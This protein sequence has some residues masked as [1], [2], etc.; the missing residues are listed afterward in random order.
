MPLLRPKPLRAAGRTLM[1]WVSLLPLAASGAGRQDVVGTLPEDYFPELKTIL[2][3][4][5]ERAPRV[6]A[7]EIEIALS[8]ARRDVADAPRL[9]Q[10]AAYL[11]AAGNQTS[12]SG[13]EGTRSRDQGFFYNVALNQAL[14]HWGA[15]KNQS[16]IARINEEIARRNHGEAYRLLALNLRQLFL[17]LV[18]KRTVLNQAQHALDL[19]EAGIEVEREKLSRGL[20]ARNSMMQREIGLRETRLY[21]RR[22]DAEFAADRRRFARLAGRSDLAEGVIPEE[23]PRPAH[24][25]A[26]A[27]ILLAVMVQDGAAS[28]FEAKVAELRMREAE[29][30]YDIEKV[31]LRPRVFVSA[32]TGLEN[33]TTATADTVTQQGV[34][35]HT[36]SLSAQWAIF[37]GFASRGARMEA[38]AVRRQQEREF[39]HVTAETLARAQQ[40]E[41]ELSFDAEALAISESQREIAAESLR[42]VAAQF[43]LGNQ[44]KS[45]VD[46]ARSGLLAREAG[47]A[48][49][50]AV[51]LSR[52][53]ELVSLAGADPVLNT[54]SER[55]ARDKR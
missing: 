15:L 20:V 12:I 40:L 2:Q 17:A 32:G 52:W 44:P 5:R 47:S 34:T 31:R 10:L 50:R 39:D 23:M 22:L 8:E 30:R 38:T 55:H 43:E 21:V 53:S 35:R 37:D 24:S 49:A 7:A 16:A 28:T 36:V 9:P 33:A 1:I 48:G 19:L 27:S 54:F 4:A 29:L 45:A 41:R 18:A 51:Y 14:F 6:I 3:L 42:Q 11:N 13:N 26:L 25:P 46:H